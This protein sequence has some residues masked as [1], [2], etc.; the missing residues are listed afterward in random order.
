MREATDEFV[1][2][3][4]RL[5]VAAQ[6]SSIIPV[7]NPLEAYCD[8]DKDLYKELGFGQITFG[9]IMNLMVWRRAMATMK[10]GHKGGPPKGD[11][12]QMGGVVVLDQDGTVAYHRA[13]HTLMDMLDL[14]GVFRVLDELPTRK[15]A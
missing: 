11:I 10:K 7:A 2:R 12:Y 8:P 1:K 13:N 6:D 4:A 5:V 14:P 15:G 3:G 9:D